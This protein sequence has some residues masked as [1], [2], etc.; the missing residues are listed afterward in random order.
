MMKKGLVLEG[1]ALR[2]LFTAG[3]IDVLMEHYIA[4]DGIVGV[5]AGAAF[6][7]NYKSK[8]PGRVI[9]YNTRFAHE[10][11]YCSLR[12]L[13]TTGDLF[14]GEFCYH[15]MPEQLDPFDWDTFEKNP[16]EFY[17][18]ATDLN[19]GEAVYKKIEQRSRE[20][21]EWFRASAS[22]PL[23]SRV[24]KIQGREMLDGGIA[25]SIPLQFF[26]SKGYERNVVV[27]TQPEDYIK[28]PNKLMP[29]M[30]I[31]LHKYPK[32]LQAMER[33]HIMYQ[34]Q[35]DWVRQEEKK[36]NILVIRP[37]QKLPIEHVSH[38]EKQMQYV[39]QQGRAIAENKIS[40]IKAFLG[41]CAN[42]NA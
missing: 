29:L 9:R 8:Q 14:G 33:R 27:L 7:C 34:A 39:Y 40:E 42:T 38:D 10:W 19:T 5:S 24:V 13:I 31:G 22:M 20:S 1:G 11:R 35:L 4:F 23:V 12:S 15:L 32:F 17:A 3:V 18:V 41:L 28:K 2:G 16:T 36:G 21:R 6:G 30:R 26:Q 37:Q 25:D